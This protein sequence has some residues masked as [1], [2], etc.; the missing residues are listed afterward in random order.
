MSD[1]AHRLDDAGRAALR[2]VAP[3]TYPD[4]QRDTLL[5]ELN[6]ALVARFGARS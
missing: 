3:A 1:A 6:R 5:L 4:D 2:E